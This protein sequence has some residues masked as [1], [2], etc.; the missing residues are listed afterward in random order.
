[1]HDR[2]L[3][4]DQQKLPPTLESIEG[5]ILKSSSSRLNVLAEKVGAAKDHSEKISKASAALKVRDQFEGS[6]K[7]SEMTARFQQAVASHDK[8]IS[9]VAERARS[10]NENVLFLVQEVAEQKAAHARRLESSL[11]VKATQASLKHDIHISRIAMLGEQHSADVVKKVGAVKEKEETVSAGIKSESEEREL[12]VTERRESILSQ[13]VADSAEH[14]REA[15]ERSADVARAREEALR[16]AADAGEERASAATA[17]RQ[18]LLND[19]VDKA[20]KTPRKARVSHEEGLGEEG[21]ENVSPGEST[22]RSTPASKLEEAAARREALLSIRSE[23]AGTDFARA[24]VAARLAK[25]NLRRGFQEGVRG[26]FQSPASLGEDQDERRQQVAFQSPVPPTSGSGGVL[27]MNYS[28]TQTPAPSS[29]YSSSGGRR[30]HRDDEQLPTPTRTVDTS[31]DAATFFGAK[32]PYQLT[33]Q[34]FEQLSL[35]TVEKRQKEGGAD[36]PGTRTPPSWCSSEDVPIEE[37]ARALALGGIRRRV[38]GPGTPYPTAEEI[39]QMRL[40]DEEALLREQE[41]EELAAAADSLGLEDISSPAATIA[42]TAPS[43]SEARGQGRWQPFSPPASSP[44]AASVSVCAHDTPHDPRLQELIGTPLILSPTRGAG[45]GINPAGWS[46]GLAMIDASPT[47]VSSAAPDRAEDPPRTDEDAK[48][49]NE[50]H[51]G[52]GQQE[53][54]KL[55]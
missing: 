38:G 53:K 15:M 41:E 31:D 14:V 17:K 22:P 19:K 9:S 54:C 8:L 7:E 29:Y 4:A 36:E 32:T 55:A 24:R 23:Q 33:D 20:A 25:E 43:D 12:A 45:P 16:A 44:S 39:A 21:S 34:D 3:A 35:F 49:E 47:V 18:E 51:E 1:M 48:K 42:A 46:G 27:D 26:D 11:K 40:R 50:D 2:L 37:V 28:S 5:R 13:I 6:K 52:G 30:M 10:H